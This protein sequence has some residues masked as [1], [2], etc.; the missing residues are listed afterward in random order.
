MCW[1]LCFVLHVLCVYLFCCVYILTCCFCCSMCSCL[2]PSPVTCHFLSLF[3]FPPFLVL[4][5][6][7]L[8]FPLC[9]VSLCIYILWVLRQ[10]VS[11]CVL[12]VS[13]PCRPLCLIVHPFPFLLRFLSPATVQDSVLV[14]ALFCLPGFVPV[15]ILSVKRNLFVIPAFRVVLSGP[16][17]RN[18]SD[19]ITT[20]INRCA[21]VCPKW[22]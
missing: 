22:L 4:T 19:I 5:C 20:Y 6:F 14:C 2:Q 18:L 7:P 16:L 11:N 12:I 8:C 1:I 17:P 13:V 3:S 9:V 10:F 15:F 21:A